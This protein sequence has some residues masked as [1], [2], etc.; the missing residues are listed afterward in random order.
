MK[1]NFYL[2]DYNLIRSN[3]S[4]SLLESNIKLLKNDKE[5]EYI[6]SNNGIYISLSFFDDYD[7]LSKYQVV[8]NDDINDVIPR[9]IT[10]T[11][12]FDDEY[13]TELEELGSFYS[14]KETTFRLWAPLNDK[15]FLVVDDKEIEMSYQGKGVFEA[16]IKGNLEKKK[17]HYKLI[18]NNQTVS[19][20]DPFAYSN[21]YDSDDSYVVDTASFN[22]KN[23]TT[24]KE[25]TPIIYE[26]SIRDFSS[27]TN[28]NFK[29]PKKFKAFLEEG[30]KLDNKSVGID[31]LKELGITH[32][33]IMPVYNFDLDNSEYN[34]GYNPVDYN[35]LYW[36]YVDSRDPYAPI[37]EFRSLVDKLHSFDIKIVLDVVYNHVY[38]KDEFPLEKILPYYFFRLYDNGKLGNASYC[39]NETRSES[40]FFREYIKLIN[41]RMITLYDVDG[42]RYD[43][44]GILDTNTANYCL[45]EARKIKDSVIMY[46]EGW[47]MGELLPEYKRA[48]INNA[49]QMK[50]YAFFNG[51]YREALRG[52]QSEKYLKGFLCSNRLFDED[53]IDGL[54]GSRKYN[55]DYNQSIN[56]VECHDNSSMFDRSSFFGYD[57]DT[58]KRICEFGLAMV[59]MSKGIP[60][61]H[62]GQE[63]LRTK[64]GVDNSYNL[65]DEINKIDWSLRVK[66]EDVVNYFKKLVKFRKEHSMF[67]KEA[68]YIEDY[69][70]LLVLKYLEYDI[71]INPYEYDYYYDSW[72]TYT[73]RIGLNYID[74]SDSK[75]FGVERLSLL[76]AKKK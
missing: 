10:H 62:A 7:D 50:N 55:L 67:E 71:I 13:K 44:M 29:Y 9:F 51:Y 11:K 35:S 36:G 64:K 40:Y 17:Y 42:F 45:S 66:N 8:V 2:D 39:G 12:R 33:Q 57:D 69:Y 53:I 72:I 46:S 14:K 52:P 70:G 65:P 34:W 28:V 56:Y 24:S 27:D 59:L 49:E 30:L 6:K 54:L 58:N 68:A 76:I 22:F 21:A 26:L 41:N 19:S 18:R 37:E 3:T 73:E 38:R 61:I 48:S 5:I 32:L 20:R 31:Y 16:T 60:F 43:L 4:E 74:I 23:I 15:A 63:F 47:N 25:E 75:S 1:V